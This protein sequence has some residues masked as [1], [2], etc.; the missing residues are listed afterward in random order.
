MS[1]HLDVCWGLGQ[2]LNDFGWASAMDESDRLG[3]SL[4]L[5]VG[6]PRATV[7]HTG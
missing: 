3:L 5:G 1:L 6:G 2:I 7:A 4:V